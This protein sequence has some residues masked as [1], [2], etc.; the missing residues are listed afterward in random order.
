MTPYSTKQIGNASIALSP[1]EQVIAVGGW[2][3]RIR[4]FSTGTGKPLGTLEYHRETVQC[5]AFPNSQQHPGMEEHGH[6]GV[7]AS[8]LEL[9]EEGSDD[10]DS[11]EEGDRAESKARWL[12]SGSKDRRL[13][14]WQLMDFEKKAED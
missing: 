3:G 4:L 10:D 7:E 5:L 9:G 8:T 13:G 2:D 1:S 12:V 6:R 11:E 14:L